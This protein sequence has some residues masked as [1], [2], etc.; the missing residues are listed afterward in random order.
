MAI[1][2]SLLCVA[3]GVY[4]WILLIRIVLSLVTAFTMW[5]PPPSLSGAVR[6]I[7]D[8]TEPPLAFVRQFLPAIG[9]FDFSPLV[10]FLIIG[11]AE[12]ALRCGGFL[13]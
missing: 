13:I 1:L 12:N 6:L 11:V 2:L 9:G 10:I 3:L 7:Y 8:L 5:V 4:R